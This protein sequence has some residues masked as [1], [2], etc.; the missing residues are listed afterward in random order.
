MCGGGGGEG[1]GVAAMKRGIG[2]TLVLFTDFLWG[3]VETVLM[4]N[5]TL[6]LE[7]NKSNITDYQL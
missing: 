7:Q 6:Y 2:R 4:N 1:S 3:L 5:N